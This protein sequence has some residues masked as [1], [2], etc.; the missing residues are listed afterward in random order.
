[1]T[2]AEAWQQALAD[3]LKGRPPST[4]A[5]IV[6]CTPAAVRSWLRG[7]SVPT[8]T[9]WRALVIEAG[10]ADRW[11]ELSAA[12]DAVERKPTGRPRLPKAVRLERL[13]KQIQEVENG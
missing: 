10:M 7:E 3:V 1:M 12:R 6:G 4:V 11:A 2:A 9:R 8:A 5:P 13:N